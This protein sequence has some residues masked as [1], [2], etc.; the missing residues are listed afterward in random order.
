[1]I[2][3]EI[4]MTDLPPIPKTESFLVVKTISMEITSRPGGLKAECLRRTV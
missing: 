1:M 3:M 2:E 4:G